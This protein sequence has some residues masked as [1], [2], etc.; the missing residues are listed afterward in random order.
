MEILNSSQEMAVHKRIERFVE[1]IDDIL[2]KMKECEPKGEFT[3]IISG[4]HDKNEPDENSEK[5]LKEDLIELINAG[6][7]HKAA[8]N[9]LSNRSNLSKNQIY[10]LILE[11]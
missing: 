2:F 3:L 5:D 1:N 9:Y 4:N 8:S 10:N 11:K 6:L 7:S